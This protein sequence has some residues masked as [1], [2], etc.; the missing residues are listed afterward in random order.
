LDG[1]SSAALC[2]FIHGL[3]QIEF[4]GPAAV[5][6][7][8]VNSQTIVCDLPYPRECGLW[9]DHHMANAENLQLRKIEPA[10]IPGRLADRPSCLRVIYEY[11]LPDFEIEEW[12]PFVAQV[13][14]IDSFQFASV[15]EWRQETAARSLDLAIRYDTSDAQ[16]LRRLALGLA[17]NDF[18]VVAR[19]PV[20]MERARAAR[21][22]EEAQ[23]GFIRKT[24]RFLDPQEQIV[25]LDLTELQKPPYFHK[26]L[27]FVLFPNAMAVLEIRCQYQRGQKTNNLGFSMSLGF[28]GA[29]VRAR[30]N[31]GEIMRKLNIGDGHPGAAA[32]HMACESKPERA[33]KLALTLQ[34]I[35]EIWNQQ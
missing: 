27:S 28:A 7:A 25:L 4:T 10:S 23:I 14:V 16:F 15:E 19:D 35:V 26:A 8:M 1:V 13:D 5:D 2:S 18:R 31:L 17:Q 32:G 22:A 3:E 33:K 34:R 24:A 30:K 29:T 12:E 9:F 20:V 6:A 21:D 11:Y